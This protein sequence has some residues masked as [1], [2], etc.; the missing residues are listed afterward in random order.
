MKQD[1]RDFFIYVKETVQELEE[2]I[3]E[4]AGDEPY[5]DD[6]AE[7]LYLLGELDSTADDALRR[8]L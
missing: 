1:L 5:T 3:D 2:G 6:Q 4:E 8:L 7:L